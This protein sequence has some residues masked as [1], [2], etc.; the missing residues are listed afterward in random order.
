MHDILRRIEDLLMKIEISFSVAEKREE[1]QSLV[2]VHSGRQPFCVETLGLEQ[3]L[4]WII[5][6]R[7]KQIL[8]HQRPLS[9]KSGIYDWAEAELRGK[10]AHT[11]QLLR[12]IRRF[13][14]LID[15][16]SSQ[17]RH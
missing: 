14:D 7:M 9:S 1:N 8:E 3:C 2:G 6:P 11:G 15:L 10:D 5:L 13:D 17:P 16:Q 4:Q 12:Q